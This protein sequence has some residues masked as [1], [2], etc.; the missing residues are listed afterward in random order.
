[1]AD[2]TTPLCSWPQFVSGAFK[3]MARNIIDPQA[4]ADLLLEATRLCEQEAGR[5][6]APFTAM[7]ET[8]RAE[9]IDPDEYGDSADVPLDQAG[10]LGR[11]YADA[12]GTSN[13]VRHCWLNEFAPRYPEMWTYS[14]VSVQV[15]R[16]YGG[17]QN[18]TATQIQGPE[19]D[20]GH[21]WF[22]LGLFI[23]I[24]S[25]VRFTYSGGY[26]TMPA[27]LVRAGKFMT[28]SLIAR[29]L[30]PT[31]TSRDPETLRADAVACLVGYTR[32]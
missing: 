1:M 11:S 4:Q 12:L 26:T 28:A 23:P 30:A 16:S 5:R 2:S 25:I 29:E 18:L 8:H 22:N 9:G 31:P 20:S 7:T 15:V 3:D 19:P 17:S 24:G 6:L 21:V 13:M 32:D 27:D 10:A 14:N